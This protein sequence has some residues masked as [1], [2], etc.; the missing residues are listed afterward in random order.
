MKAVN[1]CR[2]NVAVSGLLGCALI[3]CMV[4]GKAIAGDGAFVIRWNGQEFSVP[5]SNWSAQASWQPE[6]G[7]LSLDLRNS[8]LRAVDALRGRGCTN[9][10]QLASIWINRLWLPP[11]LLTAHGLDSVLWT[12]RWSVSYLFYERPDSRMSGPV[13]RRGKPQPLAVVMLLDGTLATESTNSLTERSRIGRPP[14]S[15]PGESAVRGDRAAGASSSEVG[16]QDLTR[17]SDVDRATFDLPR[18]QWRPEADAFPVSLSNALFGARK[19]LVSE[20]VD[21]GRELLVTEIVISRFQ[22][23][24]AIESKRER[25]SD[26]E[27]HWRLGFRF[28]VGPTV[29]PHDYDVSMTLEG[30]YLDVWLLR[31]QVRSE[32]SRSKDEQT[33]RPR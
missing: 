6:T 21:N 14:M 11:M 3:M 32:A 20:G 30:R 18:L 2:P 10:V 5:G 1:P 28:G 24:A 25:W 7:A 27:N 22:P 8:T 31:S 16:I 4:V 15:S 33:A 12:N 26:H 13:E 29:Q 9:E 17:T 23:N 19:L